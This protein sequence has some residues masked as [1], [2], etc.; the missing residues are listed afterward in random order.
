MR[1]QATVFKLGLSHRSPHSAPA[2]RP[3]TGGGV[4]ELEGQVSHQLAAEGTA[5]QLNPEGVG[6][7]DTQGVVGV[8]A[9]GHQ[10]GGGQV[11]ISVLH[12]GKER[13]TPG[14]AMGEGGRSSLACV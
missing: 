13:V 9:G 4:Q 5:V 2:P 12:E 3:L 14:G 7:H 6:H 8:L 1:A 11:G 10:G